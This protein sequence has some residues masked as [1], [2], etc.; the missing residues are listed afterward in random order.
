MPLLYEPVL[1]RDAYCHIVSRSKLVSIFIF[2]IF[3]FY[4]QKQFSIVRPKMTHSKRILAV[5]VI[6]YYIRMVG[7]RVTYHTIRSYKV[8]VHKPNLLL[9]K[10]SVEQLQDLPTQQFIIS[11]HNHKNLIRFT[12]ISSSPSKVRHGK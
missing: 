1:G 9:L 4:I 5:L 3:L 10:H 6:L 11:I 12:E 7:S 8:S 2:Q